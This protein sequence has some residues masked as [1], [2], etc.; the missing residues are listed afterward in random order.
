[1]TDFEART[2]YKKKDRSQKLD[3]GNNPKREVGQILQD[4]ENG[5]IVAFV[6]FF[7]LFLKLYC[8]HHTL[9]MH[10]CQFHALLY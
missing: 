10:P 2:A 6:A 3:S 4:G 5:Q 1:M 9:Q 7:N 8:D